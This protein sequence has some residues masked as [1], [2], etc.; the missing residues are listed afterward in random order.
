MN[1]DNA[2][3]QSISLT[4]DEQEA[5]VPTMQRI[6][7]YQQLLQESITTLQ[8]VITL[9]AKNHSVDPSEYALSEDGTTLV[10]RSQTQR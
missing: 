5:V 10:Y 7:K 2:A 1:T 3:Q 9:L 6:G 4:A 8:P